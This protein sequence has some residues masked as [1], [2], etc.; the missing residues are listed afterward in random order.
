MTSLELLAAR[1]DREATRT[2]KRSV[3]CRA[4][5]LQV[6]ADFYWG[7]STAYRI[8]GELVRAEVQ[9]REE[10]EQGGTK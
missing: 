7:S 8:C 6:R 3:Q 1:M 2:A 10:I 5:G 9:A 4:K